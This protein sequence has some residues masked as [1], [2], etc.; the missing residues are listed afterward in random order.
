MAFPYTTM[1]SFEDGTLG[2][3]DA[4]TDTGSKLDFP[5]YTELARHP[6]LPA[7]YRGAYCMR[8]DLAPSTNQA[9]VQETG[10]WDLTAGTDEIY[11]RLKLWISK[12]L[13][14]ATTDEFAILQFWSSTNTLEAGVFVNYTTANGYRL[15]LGATSGSS[16]KSLTLG[17]WH[18]IEVYFNPAGGAAGTLD[19]WLDNSAFTQVGSLTNANITSGVVGVDLQDAGTTK[20]R[21]LF[22]AIVGHKNG[23]RIGRGGKRFEKQ[24]L[25]EGTRHLFVGHGIID[26]VSLL[27]GGAAD[28]ILRIWDTD[29]ADTTNASMKLELR[30]LNADETPVDPAGVPVEVTHGCYVELTGTNPRAIANIYRASGYYSDAAIRDAAMVGT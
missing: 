26:N 13:T 1:A 23:A 15:G 2:H 7:P 27:S 3:F 11:L 28:N 19:G 25:I 22:D 16:W 17:E 20:G 30:N 14:M 9:I 21:V 8:V 29:R 18:D 5:H 10:A 24:A 12:D 6:G 4:E